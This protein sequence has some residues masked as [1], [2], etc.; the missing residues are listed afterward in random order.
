M[1][2][3]VNEVSINGVEYVRKDSIQTGQAP[4]V[5]GLKRCIVRSYGAGVFFGY[6]KEIRAELN[7]VNVV[8]LKAKRIHYWSGACSLSQLAIDGTKD[9]GN[10]RITEP[11]DEQFVANVIEIIPVTKAAAENIDGVPVWKK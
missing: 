3:T 7:G 11:V 4:T 9:G 2:Q 5:D 6:V 1:E 10:C 8:L